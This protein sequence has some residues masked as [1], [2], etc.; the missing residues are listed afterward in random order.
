MEYRVD[1]CEAVPQAMLRLPRQ[2]RPDRLGEDIAEGMRELTATARRAG[3]TTNGAPTITFPE[4]LLPDETTL[5][6]FAVPI[7]PASALGLG[8]DAEVVV[9]PGTL[10]ARTSH[11][12]DYGGIA[13]AYRALREWILQA[14]Y[15]PAGPPTEAFLVGPDEASDA[16][17]LVTEIRM[18]I[19]SEPAITVYL[20]T[21]FEKSLT[22]TREALQ[23]HGFGILTEIDVRGTLQEKLGENLEP[24]VVLGACNP[25][26]AS[27]A[28]HID[29]QAG[30]LLP[31]NVVVR[32]YGAG[33][34]V[35][36][37]DPETLVRITGQPDLAGVAGQARRL[38]TATLFELR[39]AAAT[40]PAT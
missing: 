4:R 34:L 25:P 33:A 35:E 14:G 9:L 2:I 37:A 38:L 15:R 1:V 12:G 5:V 36:A 6:D 18:P 23:R 26:L 39:A 3:L 7:E 20:P 29:R 40:T 28:L 16:R 17:L 32:A 31:C 8:P 10:V 13:T 22:L 27:R 24:F 21:P 19:A 11:R 30:L